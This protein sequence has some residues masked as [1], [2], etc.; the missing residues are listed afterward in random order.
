M[1]LSQLAGYD[2][3]TMSCLILIVMI[4]MCPQHLVYNTWE[5][6]LMVVVPLQCLMCLKTPVMCTQAL[7]SPSPFQPETGVERMVPVLMHSTPS[8]SFGRY[9]LYTDAV[10]IDLARY[11]SYCP[12]QLFVSVILVKTKK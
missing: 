2:H 4:S 7:P 3:Q 9:I 10:L 1:L 12:D 5:S 8:V 11:V 6:W